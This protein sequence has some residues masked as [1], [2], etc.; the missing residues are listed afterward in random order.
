VEDFPVRGRLDLVS[1]RVNIDRAARRSD[2]HLGRT[3]SHRK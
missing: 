1:I 3:R 2:D